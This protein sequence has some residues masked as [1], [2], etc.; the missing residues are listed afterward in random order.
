MDRVLQRLLPSLCLDC[1]LPFLTPVLFCSPVGSPMPC[2]TVKLMISH[3]QTNH[4]LT[5]GES[6]DG[7]L[8][9]FQVLMAPRRR[10]AASWQLMGRGLC[11]EVRLKEGILHLGSDM[12][13]T[14]GGPALFHLGLM[15][16]FCSSDIILSEMVENCKHFQ[17]S[18]ASCLHGKT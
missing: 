4:F 18:K 2:S 5:D 12:Q 6:A 1:L 3:Y 14:F 9:I 7:T 17:G 15:A 11:L 10:L 13:F 8:L 16:L